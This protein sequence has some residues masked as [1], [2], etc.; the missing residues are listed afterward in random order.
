M[1]LFLAHVDA[2][3]LEMPHHR[4][5]YPA[6]EQLDQAFVLGL[7]GLW[8]HEHRAFW[9]FLLD[10]V[11]ADFVYLREHHFADLDVVGL[12]LSMHQV[13]R[14]PVYCNSFL[15]L[16]DRRLLINLRLLGPS[17]SPQILIER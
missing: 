14:G 16:P 11:L 9:D 15:I 12:S 5:V 1:E 13:D 7:R 8:E 3:L 4:F 2:L 6:Q 10:L 17:R